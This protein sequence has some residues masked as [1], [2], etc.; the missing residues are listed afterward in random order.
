MPAEHTLEWN[1]EEF[2]IKRLAFSGEVA[3]Y[4]FLHSETRAQNAVTNIPVKAIKGPEIYEGCKPFEVNVTITFV[5]NILTPLEA[6]ELAAKIVRILYQHD[7]SFAP[8]LP[9]L[10]FLSLENGSDTQR[11]NR[12]KVQVRV[13]SL[14]FFAKLRP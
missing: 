1:V 12:N 8:E 14:P 10:F 3:G 6:D 7:P 9:D 2:I 13:I 4:D 11:E 5:S